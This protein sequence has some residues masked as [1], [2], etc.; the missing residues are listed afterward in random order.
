MRTVRSLKLLTKQILAPIYFRGYPITLK[1]ERLYL[2]M[3]ILCKTMEIEGDVIE[4]GVMHGGTSIISAKL[5]RGLGS[6]KQYH[7]Y[8]TFGGFVENQVSDEINK[9]LD[10]QFRTHFQANSEGLV[11]KIFRLHGVSEIK[12]VKGDIMTQDKFPEKISAALLDVD[13][14]DPTYAALTKVYERLSNG[15]IIAIDDCHRMPDGYDGYRAAEGV[16]RFADEHKV[17]VTLDRGMGFICKGGA[18][19]NHCLRGGGI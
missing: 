18:Y 14:A 10:P 12:T 4:V 19:V 2:W 16:R 5:L 13:L 11:R 7:A 17:S 15:G 9:G 3:D 8:D 1:A 6:Q